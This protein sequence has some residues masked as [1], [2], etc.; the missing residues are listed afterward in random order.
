MQELRLYQD[1]LSIEDLRWVNMSKEYLPLC[2]P[3]AWWRWARQ[4]A[5]S[6]MKAYFRWSRYLQTAIH[7]L[8]IYVSS[9]VDPLLKKKKRTYCQDEERL[10]WQLQRLTVYSWKLKILQRS[11]ISWKGCFSNRTFLFK[12]V[13][14]REDV[15]SQR[16]IIIIDEC[17]SFINI[18]DRNDWQNGTKNLSAVK[19]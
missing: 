19:K 6:E 16:M 2:W 5:L 4:V 15:Q 9:Y 12:C 14:F 1:G 8:S 10:H 13:V 11:G 7:R 3:S 17:N 18:L